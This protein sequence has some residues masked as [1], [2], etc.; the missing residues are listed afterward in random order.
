MMAD[1]SLDNQYRENWMRDNYNFDPSVS[2][3]L[4]EPYYNTR[5]E[6]NKVTLATSNRFS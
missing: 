4:R 6:I 3:P 5:G 2:V 1:R